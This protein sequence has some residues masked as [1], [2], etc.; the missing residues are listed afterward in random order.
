MTE[1]MTANNGKY[2]L[3]REQGATF[4]T[5]E[6]VSIVTKIVYIGLGIV[7]AINALLKFIP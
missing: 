1:R 4:A 5:K 2:E 6:E 7:I 3:L